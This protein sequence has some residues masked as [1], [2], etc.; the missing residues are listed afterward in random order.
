LSNDPQ[1]KD[2]ILE[3]AIVPETMEQKIANA[4]NDFLNTGLDK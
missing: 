4:I 3:P 1:L 2:Q